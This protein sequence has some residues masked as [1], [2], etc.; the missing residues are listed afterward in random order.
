M[1]GYDTLTQ[2]LE[3][4]ER[5]LGT[6]KPITTVAELARESGY[7]THHFSRLFFSHTSMHLKEYLQGRLLTCLMVQAATESTPF[8]ALASRYGFRDYETFYRACRTRWNKTPTQMRQSGLSTQQKQERIHP[9]KRVAPPALVGQLVT[10]QTFTLCGL[11]FFIGPETKSFHAIWAQ[12]SRYEHLIE[13]CIDDRTTYQFSAWTDEDLPGMSVL[14]AKP[15][16]KMWA[17]PQVFTVRTIAAASYVRFI[18]S[19]DITSIK[20]TYHYIYGTY[21]AQSP[22]QPLGNW[23]FQRYRRGDARIEIFIPVRTGTPLPS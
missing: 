22:L 12:F 21:F 5:S 17:G 14:C 15:V 10:M 2:T 19:G 16:H 7:S 13:H 18:H 20:E 8:A 3:R 4:F 1:D 6:D 9:Q 11:N 23:E